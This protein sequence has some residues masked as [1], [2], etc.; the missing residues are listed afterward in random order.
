[1]RKLFFGAAVALLF[2]CASCQKCTV[3][4]KSNATDVRICKKDYNSNTAYG[5][6][7]DIYKAMNYDCTESW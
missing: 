3:C 1:M 6:A 4:T 5:A 7:V 2:G